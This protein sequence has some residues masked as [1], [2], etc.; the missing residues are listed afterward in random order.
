MAQTKTKLAIANGLIR[1]YRLL[2]GRPQTLLPADPAPKTIVVFSTTALGDLMF[3]T[4]AIRQLRLRFPQARLILVVHQKYVD[5]V[6]RYDD[7]DQVLCWDGRF[8]RMRGFLRDLRPMKPDLAV[9]LHSR[10]PFDILCAVLAGCRWIV[11]DDIPQPDGP[12]MRQWLAAASDNAFRGHVIQRKLTLLKALGCDDSQVAMRVPCAIDPQH[13]RV[14]GVERIGFQLG[15]S[16]PER[17]W[18]VSHFVALAEALLQVRPACQIV[19]TGMASELALA[20]QFFALLPTHWHSR[21]I[22]MVGQTS[23]QQ[24]FELVAS[25][26]LLVTGDT[27]PLHLAIAQ[28]VP[29]V[30]LFVTADPAETG[31]YQDPA[32]H[33]VIR[34]PLPANASAALR[35]EP[36]ANVP[37]ETVLSAV[38]QALSA[39]KV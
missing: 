25:L 24:A 22:S 33:T 27:G 20:E 39:D 38:L 30:S 13:F 18:P 12:P 2:T 31:P 4:P 5:L 14:A 8:V 29:T 23:V 1:M 17:S 9:I 16:K 6:Q 11:R 15:A 37:V 34:R 7:V 3:N 21:V 10:V 26:N 19:L 35:A 32:L 28:Q 36:M